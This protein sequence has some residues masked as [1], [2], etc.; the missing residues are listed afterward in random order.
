MALGVRFDNFGCLRA[1]VLGLI[2][3]LIFGA[4]LGQEVLDISLVFDGQKYSLEFLI[5]VHLLVAVSLAW[6][7]STSSAAW[8]GDAPLPV[9]FF[10]V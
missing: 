5:E 7:L 9:V 1:P 10:H 6:W 3:S 4:E 8:L 2:I